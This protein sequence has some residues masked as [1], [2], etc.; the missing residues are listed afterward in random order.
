MHIFCS[1]TIFLLLA[2]FTTISGILANPFPLDPTSAPSPYAIPEIPSSNPT[3]AL[4]ATNNHAGPLSISPHAIV[5][6][7]GTRGSFYTDWTDWLGGFDN[8]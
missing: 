2:S 1:T 3:P 5:K 8:N 7:D 6:S 4:G